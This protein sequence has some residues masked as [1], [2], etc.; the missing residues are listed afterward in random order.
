M[1]MD[2]PRYYHATTVH[3]AQSICQIGFRSGFQGLAG[4]G[5]YDIVCDQPHLA[6]RRCRCRCGC[7]TILWLYAVDAEPCEGG[8]GNFVIRYPQAQV[9]RF[10]V[11][12]HY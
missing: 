5:L 3:N 10:G 8:M 12:Y 4:P 2:M 11:L 7:R 9:A 6:E 1:A